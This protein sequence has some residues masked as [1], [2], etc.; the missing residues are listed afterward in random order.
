MGD[1]LEMS[2]I[3]KH[4]GGIYALSG[5]SFAARSGEVHGL[6]GEN[7]AGKSTLMKILSGA[8]QS[9]AGEI[10]L[11]GMPAHIRTPQDAIAH[12]ISVIYQEFSL[13][14]HLSV[15]ENILIEEMGHA[16]SF[17]N[18]SDMNR[19]ASM[20]L[21]EMG[22]GEIDPKMRAGELSV[23]YQQ[24]V[25]ICKA[26]SRD[27]CV[28]V[29]D[30]PTAVLTH[31]ETRKLFKLINDLRDRGVCII[32]ISHRLEEIFELCDRVTVLKD[33]ETVGTHQIA[34]LTEKYLISMM[35]G[36][37]LSDL[38]PP[39]NAVIG[40]QRLQVENLSAGPV[41][42]DVS[43]NVRA[44]E[45]VGFSGLVGAGRTETMRAIFGAHQVHSGTIYLDGQEIC[46]NTPGQAVGRGIGMVPEDR[47]REGV[48][49]DLPIRI[50]AML[51]PL[52][53]F[54]SALG[55]IDQKGEIEA[56][57][58]MADA[59]QLKAA[60]LN[61]EVSALSGGNQQKVALMKWMAAGCSVLIFDEP[62]RGVDVG[63]KAEIYQVMNDLA[64]Q[65]VAIVMISSE[66]LEVIGMSDRVYV[67]RQGRISGELM[68]KDL[69][70]QKLLELAMGT[71]GI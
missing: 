48:L 6:M 2:G 12:G 21:E 3:K 56:V 10:R 9:D 14:E 55:L 71:E 50:N 39:R 32:Y 7:G 36:R 27:S 65:G 44:G 24:V 23:A 46:N 67:M 68:K 22:F 54:V 11:D 16:G 34:D 70:E 35:I 53:R 51:T 42:K 37:D 57:T 29:F 8:Y 30:E 5:V 19:R 26:L 61:L 63:A 62:T 25:E 45:I 52:N 40:E 31:H 41:V 1:Y 18:W 28:I 64:E 4:F 17:V 33:G 69:T 59:L 60:S 58:Q 43:F 66:M 49:L 13:A 47:K 15:A 20:L 38:F